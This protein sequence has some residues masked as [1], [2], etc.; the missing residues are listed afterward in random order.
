MQFLERGFDLNW[1]RSKYLEMLRREN[2]VIQYR[3]DEKLSA[4]YNLEREN[5]LP[6][7]IEEANFPAIVARGTFTSASVFSSIR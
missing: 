1:N 7:G 5:T 6:T 4:L 3:W 2:K